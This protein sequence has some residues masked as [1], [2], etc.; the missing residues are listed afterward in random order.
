MSIR[1]RFPQA[2][3]PRSHYFLTVSRGEKV[4]AFAVRP[5]VAMV[6][7][8]AAPLFALWA[9][10]ATAF[11][12]CH[13]S[14]VTALLSREAQIETDYETKLSAARAE[15]DHVSSRQLLDQNA[16]EGK[17]R[18]LASRQAKLE[19]RGSALAALAAEAS[20]NATALAEARPRGVA[21]AASNALSAIQAIGGPPTDGD[22]GPA[23]AY[24]P[25]AA[26]KAAPAAPVKPRPLDGD[27][28]SRAEPA[29]TDRLARELADAAVDASL[30]PNARIGLVD[31]SLDR[32]ERAQLQTLNGVAKAAHSAAQKFEAVVQRTGLSLAS[33]KAPEAKEA[34]GVGGPYIPVE[35]GDEA[36]A[37][38]VTDA[39]REIEAARKLR[40]L[41]P[42]LPVR[43]PLV[44]DATLSSPF[45]YR[46]DPFLGRPALH[47]G[48]DLVQAFGSEIKA[49]AVGRVTHAGPMGGYGNCVEIDHGNGV[50][51][52]YGHMSEV[53]VEEGQTVGVGEAIGRIGSTGR[54]TGPH[55]HYEVRVD[56][57]PVDPERFLTAARD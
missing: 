42:H 28:L 54:S 51:T 46:P 23:S 6:A 15:L 8:A 12:A 14:V 3:L 43:Y 49:T 57:E 22:L 18:D 39:A 47:P 56:G 13:D 9:C 48:V 30:D 2:K 32:V 53:L 29:A 10:G 41:M 5:S 24:A 44:G 55:L 34:A 16:F 31:Y 26:P 40:R 11:I 52:R 7:L 20:A 19:Q 36:F 37:S 27:N 33:I 21:R 25:V 35:P 1:D 38:A 45:G 17:M 4:R 50:A